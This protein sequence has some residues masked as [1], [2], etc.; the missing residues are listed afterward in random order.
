ML[1]QSSVSRYRDGRTTFLQVPRTFIA[2]LIAADQAAGG[3]PT[4]ARR[5]LAGTAEA[6]LSD[7]ETAWAL[8]PAGKLSVTAARRHR[9]QLRKQ[10]KQRRGLQQDGYYDE[11]Y[12]DYGPDGYYGPYGDYPYYEFYDFGNYDYYYYDYEWPDSGTAQNTTGEY[13]PNNTSDMPTGGTEAVISNDP[14][15]QYDSYSNITHDDLTEPMLAFID[16]YGS[17]SECAISTRR[18]EEL[19]SLMNPIYFDFIRQIEIEQVKCF[20]MHE[21]VAWPFHEPRASLGVLPWSYPS[22][23][24]VKSVFHQTMHVVP[25]DGT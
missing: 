8:A 19:N 12:A 23:N 20:S 21:R 22:H 9:R 2:E 17:A 18:F 5:R 1:M 16:K 13:M 24:A 15:Q 6:S 25:R 4:T 7:L 10:R 14:N 11:P 3:G